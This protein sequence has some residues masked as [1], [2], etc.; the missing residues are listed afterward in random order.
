MGK[1]IDER[2][3][4]IIRSATRSFLHKHQ[5]LFANRIREGKVRDCHGDLRAG[6]IYFAN[7]IKIIDCIEFNDRF[8]Y[9]DIACDLAFLAMDLDFEGFG[10]IEQQL[11]E[12]FTRHSN[13]NQ[14]FI[15]LDFYKCYRAFVRVK[16][17]CLRL[18]E[19]NLGEYESRRLQRETNKYMEL[20][21]RYALT[22][23]RP[24]LWMICGIIGSGKSTT[25]LALGQVLKLKVLQSDAVRKEMFGL[26][27]TAEVDVPFGTGIY[28]EES[29]RLTYAKM[30]MLAQE[31]MKRGCSVIMDATFSRQCHRISARRLAED[32]DSNLIIV[33][34]VAGSPVIR[35]R[36]LARQTGRSLSDA[37][38]H[39]LPE[40]QNVFEPLTE[41]EENC[42]IR[43]NTELCVD[44]NIHKILSERRGPCLKKL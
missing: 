26:D 22:I 38:L 20:A 28:S 4:Q 35:Q 44:D 39:H 2:M 13:D 8:R 31:E 29:N 15:L 33:E 42:S 6:H 18:E 16:V 5:A 32:L 40:F 12:A 36:L 1:I 14:I 21:Y 9:T 43:V 23:N 11:L 7:G 25:A 17:N 41:E 34:C 3:Y 37:R 27:P 19:N 24:T 10:E 30:L